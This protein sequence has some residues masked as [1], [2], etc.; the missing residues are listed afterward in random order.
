VQ[1][2]QKRT[3][4]RTF[5]VELQNPDFQLLAQAFGVRS[6]RVDSPAGLAAAL[7]AAEIAGGPSLIE[8]QVGEMPSPWALI[9]PFVPPASPPPP[10][11]LGEPRQA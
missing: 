3:F 1:R 10:N 4:G 8:V 2:I 5:A 7:K 6:E 9:H 11:P